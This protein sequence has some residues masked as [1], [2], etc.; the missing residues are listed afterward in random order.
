V[1]PS[2]AFSGTI[3]ADSKWKG[4]VGGSQ[5]DEGYETEHESEDEAGDET[6]NELEED[7]FARSHWE[8]SG[9]K[10]RK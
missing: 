7:E 1:S 6:E 4:S 10:G 9:S 8:G 3:R 5:G 2:S